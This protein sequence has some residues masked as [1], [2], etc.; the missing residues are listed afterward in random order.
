[1]ENFTLY[2]H[3]YFSKVDLEAL[4]FSCVFNCKRMNRQYAII[5]KI[6][7]DLFA[8][9]IQINCS[10]LN[11]TRLYVGVCKHHKIELVRFAE[12]YKQKWWGAK[13]GE[14]WNNYQIKVNPLSGEFYVCFHAFIGHDLAKDNEKFRMKMTDE[15]Q[16]LGEEAEKIFNTVLKIIFNQESNDPFL[17]SM[18]RVGINYSKTVKLDQL[19]AKLKKLN[20]IAPHYKIRQDISNQNKT[21][22][23]FK[24]VY[25]KKTESTVTTG[26]V[27]E[28]AMVYCNKFTKKNYEA[29]QDSTHSSARTRPPKK[30]Y[31]PIPPFEELM[32]NYEVDYAQHLQDNFPNKGT[33][34]LSL[35]H[36][37]TA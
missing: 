10:L 7:G 12:S 19:L 29:L 21:R 34:V 17:K 18:E 5:G 25:L 28:T 1:M 20:A 24:K 23:Y 8:R 37:L 16:K 11:F 6:E 9:T 36:V 31:I 14:K 2:D 32:D 35:A 26:L 22:S 27:L 3:N 15:C 13:L 4:T 30:K 33:S